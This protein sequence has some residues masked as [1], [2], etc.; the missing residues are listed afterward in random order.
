MVTGM[1]LQEIVTDRVRRKVTVVLDHDE[2]VA[3]GQHHAIPDCSCHNA[4]PGAAERSI[5]SSLMP[6]TRSVAKGATQPTMNLGSAHCGSLHGLDA[7][8][9]AAICRHDHHLTRGVSCPGGAA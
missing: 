5:A 4:P 3:F 9:E 8:R 2:V 1:F 6:A 7:L